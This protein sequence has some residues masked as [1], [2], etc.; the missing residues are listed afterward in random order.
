MLNYKTIKNFY[1]KG[2]WSSE[3]V[4]MSVRKGILTDKEAKK[5]LEKKEA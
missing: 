3:L 4:L 2:L 5:I 1:I